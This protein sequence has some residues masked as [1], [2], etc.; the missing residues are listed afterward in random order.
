MDKHLSVAFH[1]SLFITVQIGQGICAL[2]CLV[3][4]DPPEISRQYSL[5]FPSYLHGTDIVNNFNP[6]LKFWGP[7]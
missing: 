2:L 7:F 1:V 5:W 3:P 6:V 4:E